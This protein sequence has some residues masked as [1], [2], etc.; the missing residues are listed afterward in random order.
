MIELSVY[1]HKTEK[2]I[3]LTRN[4]SI[5][6]GGPTTEFYYA[7]KDINEA[8]KSANRDGFLSWT[9]GFRDLTAK[10]ILQ[11]EMNFDGYTGKL[12]KKTSLPVSDF[13][14]ILLVEREAHDEG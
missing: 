3:Y 1:R 7:T 8:I 10:I 4:W 2:D 6:G 9:Q 11:K 12:E 5:C 14:R 13:E